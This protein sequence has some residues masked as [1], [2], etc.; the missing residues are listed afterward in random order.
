MCLLIS[1]YRVLKVK[2]FYENMR[3]IKIGT[4]FWNVFLKH[5]LPGT[6][7]VSATTYCTKGYNVSS[8]IYII[9]RIF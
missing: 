6:S 5:K 1:R 2:I 3:L 4:H 9:L 8:I 7:R